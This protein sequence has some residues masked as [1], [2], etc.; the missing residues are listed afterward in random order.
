MPLRGEAGS[1]S[2]RRGPSV[3]LAR[4]D[5]ELSGGQ[6]GPVLDGGTG[7]RRLRWVRTR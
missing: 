5:L 3:N 2:G 7:G 1:G 6:A 4:K